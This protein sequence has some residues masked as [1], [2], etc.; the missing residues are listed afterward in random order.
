[1][2]RIAIARRLRR[3]QTHAEALLWD[4]VRGRR[5]ADAKFRRQAPIDRYVADFVCVEARLIVEL[6]GGAH[7]DE[8]AQ[9]KDIERT[10]VLEACGY[11]LLRFP[12]ALVLNEPGRVCDVIKATLRAAHL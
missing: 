3:E 12:N 2:R 8:D 11:F 1:M 7:D 6:D 4:L 10:K 5:L 9:L